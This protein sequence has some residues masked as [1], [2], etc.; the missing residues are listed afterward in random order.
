MNEEVKKKRK[1]SEIDFSEEGSHVA[2]CHKSNPAANNRT[3]LLFK[4]KATSEITQ[5]DIQEVLKSKSEKVAEVEKAT[6]NSQVKGM[7][8][9]ALS[10]KY[11]D[12][13]N[14]LCIEDFSESE[15]VFTT[16]K[17]MYVVSYSLNEDDTYK[18]ED[19]A[20]EV[21]LKISPSYEDTGKVMVSEYAE[22]M[23]EDG[24]FGLI[25]KSLKNPETNER[26]FG[27]L[28]SIQKKEKIVKEEIQKAVD[29][30]KAEA[31]AEM[32]VVQAELTKA[33]ELLAEVEAAKKQAVLKARQEKVATVAAD[34]AEALVKATESLEDEA[35][36]TI[37]KALE[38]KAQVSQESDLMKQMSVQGDGA[39]KE[40]SRTLELLKSKQ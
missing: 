34:Q 7:L 39:P 5:D 8:Y 31:A 33:R 37:F 23:L 36:E 24:V 29:A 28:T 16:K 13:D 32:A 14:W 10:E 20:R 30:V 35:F 1:L 21:R 3:T 22:D 18:V 6:F 9:A 2:L 17:G 15:I 38:A 25:T 26:L 4:T 27:V 19:T 11:E 40:S 12:G